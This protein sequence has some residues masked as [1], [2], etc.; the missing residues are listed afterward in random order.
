MLQENALKFDR[1]HAYI[2]P[3]KP[4]ENGQYMNKNGLLAV[5]LKTRKIIVT[6][7]ETTCF[8]LETVSD[9]A[10]RS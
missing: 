6:S 5:I 3:Q 1:D 9:R 8:I 7:M 4:I 2:I 10:K